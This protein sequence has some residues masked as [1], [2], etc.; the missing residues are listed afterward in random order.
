LICLFD[1]MKAIIDDDDDDLLLE[2]DT[3]D[4]EL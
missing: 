1:E 2:V 3:E 4:E